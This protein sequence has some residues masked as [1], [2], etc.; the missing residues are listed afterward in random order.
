[1]TP[2]TALLIWVKLGFKRGACSVNPCQVAS[3]GQIKAQ[4]ILTRIKQTAT[5][6]KHPIS[7]QTFGIQSFKRTGSHHFRR[8]IDIDNLINKT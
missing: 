8:L 7:A 1:M 5:R 2:R 6:F 4:R 3:I